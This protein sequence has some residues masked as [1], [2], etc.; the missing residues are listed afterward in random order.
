VETEKVMTEKSITNG[1][2]STTYHNDMSAARAARDMSKKPVGRPNETKRQYN[3]GEVQE[4]YLDGF[5]INEIAMQTGHSYD[6]VKKYVSDIVTALKEYNLQTLNE[7]RIKSIRK[8][9]HLQSRAEGYV[10]DRNPAKG[11]S[12]A[13]EAEMNIA[14]LDGLLV[15]K[16]EQ[17]GVT[18][19]KVTVEREKPVEATG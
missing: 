13:M 12:L 1:I 15:D 7:K 8:L 3:M 11:V 4:L 18:E 6:T 9:R 14:K 16:V 19:I 17:S 2:G 10:C 5:T